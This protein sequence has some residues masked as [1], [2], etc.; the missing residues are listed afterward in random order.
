MPITMC[1]FDGAEV[2]IGTVTI[3][4]FN[5][6]TYCKALQDLGISTAV[7]QQI[8]TSMQLL[9]DEK[10][11]IMLPHLNQH[12]TEQLEAMMIKDVAFGTGVIGYAYEVHDMKMNHILYGKE[13]WI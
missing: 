12:Y 8:F 7:S 6:Q 4:F 5:T 2:V 13:S 1:G 10:I 9:R 11:G 3:V